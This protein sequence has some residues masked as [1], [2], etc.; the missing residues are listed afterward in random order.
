MESSSRAV[1]SSSPLSQH[2]IEGA[3]VLG[4]RGAHRAEQP[5]RRFVVEGVR[6]VESGVV[7]GALPEG[8]SCYGA[9]SADADRLVV[10]HGNGVA[11]FDWSGERI[12]GFA[13]PLGVEVENGV[14]VAPGGVAFAHWESGEI[15]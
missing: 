11:F 6:L 14:A 5:F 4:Q 13:S 7:E 10:A 1:V 2:G 15:E 9:A 12:G 3:L 8:V